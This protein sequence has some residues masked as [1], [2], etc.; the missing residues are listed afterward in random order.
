M[1]CGYRRISSTKPR[2][3]FSLNRVQHHHFLWIAHHRLVTRFHS[4]G[5][6]VC[7]IIVRIHATGLNADVYVFLELFASFLV[8]FE[9]L[10]FEV[11]T[12]TFHK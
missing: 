8:G 4:W 3:T 1:S 12:K 10:G 6:G 7:V 9:F 2:S 11:L 5:S